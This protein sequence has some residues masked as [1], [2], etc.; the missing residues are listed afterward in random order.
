MLDKEVVRRTARY[1]AALL[2]ALN[3]DAPC[4]ELPCGVSY[5]AVFVFAKRH[6]VAG[7]IWYLIEDEVRSTGD[8]ELIERFEK[9]CMLDYNKHRAQERELAA[10]S[11]ALSE[12]SI[13]HLPLKGFIN[14]ALW[15]RPEYRTMTDMD[16]YVGEDNIA[17]AAEVLSSL[18]YK[19]S[20]KGAV[21]DAYEKPPYV[22]VEL[23]KK[24]GSRENGDF[25]AWKALPS[26][27]HHY[28][29]SDEDFLLYAIGHMHK[30]YRQGGSGMRSFFDVYLYLKKKGEALDFD[31]IDRELRQ[32][33]LSEFYSSVLSLSA[34]W[35]D[36]D[37]ER[38]SELSE[39]EIYIA[40]GGTFGT[41]ENR[42]K[43]ALKK[44]SRL[45]YALS[46]IFLPYRAM[47]EMYGWLRPLPFLLPVAWVIRLLS[48]L[49]DG[50]M[51]R[52]IRAVAKA[53][54]AEPTAP[55]EADG[56]AR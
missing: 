40:T 51:R 22:N 34:L 6:A 16:I 53:A 44:K 29:M 41:V 15:K 13:D 52:E 8:E 32:R 36:G 9:S 23:H 3:C 4:P 50:R 28:V 26:D 35:F 42:T 12:R 19:L 49:L 54:E 43:H 39:L 47:K 48:A 21:H 20:H 56:K 37:L 18:G 10:I 31:H 38:E 55:T 5:R 1:V 30:H 24:L 25:S 14:K 2:V 17:A 46:R 33:G 45:R 27:P 7:A 11:A